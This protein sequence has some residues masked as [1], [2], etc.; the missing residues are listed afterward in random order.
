MWKSVVNQVVGGSINSL[1]R[2]SM[3]EKPTIV[4][5][6]TLMPLNSS[7]NCSRTRVLSQLLNGNW[8]LPIDVI[9]R[10]VAAAQCSD[11][12]TAHDHK[13]FVASQRWGERE[14]PQRYWNEW[15][16]PPEFSLPWIIL[17]ALVSPCEI[18]TVSPAKR[19]QWFKNK[20]S[21]AYKSHSSSD[22]TRC[23]YLQT[24]S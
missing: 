12:H 11:D 8:A 9:S 15:Q 6:P 23:A 7:V 21:H 10:A 16:I 22:E 19:Q 3:E 13:A 24:P 17:M 5:S 2:S 18:S 1:I 20:I 4:S 14:R